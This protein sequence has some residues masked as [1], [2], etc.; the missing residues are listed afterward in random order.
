MLVR[1]SG[2]TSGLLGEVLHNCWPLGAVADVLDDFCTREAGTV[3]VVD[4]A[5]PMMTVPSGTT[6]L[7]PWV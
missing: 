5:S 7:T 2:S 6:A 4:L 3:G 1:A